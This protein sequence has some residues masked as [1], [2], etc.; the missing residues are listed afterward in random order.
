MKLLQYLKEEKRPTR[1]KN[2][3]EEEFTEAV[4]S[5]CKPALDAVPI[6]R[7]NPAT[8]FDFGFIS[9]GKYERRSA[10]T[11]NWYALLINNSSTWK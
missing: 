2:I 10:N 11:D 1:T 3:S 9:P 7:G 6:Y 5:K 4:N 8:K